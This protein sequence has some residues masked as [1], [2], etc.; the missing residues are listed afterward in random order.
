MSATPSTD[1]T[2]S[3]DLPADAVLFDCD[4]VLVDS[5]ASVVAAWSRWAADVGLDPDEVVPQVHGRR[6][7]DTVAALVAEPERVAALER[8][9]RYELDAAA[10]VT[11]VPGAAALTAALPAG[12]WAV[13][14]SGTRALATARLAAAGVAAPA[15]LV[16]ADDV[17]AGKPAPDGY[18]LAAGR[19]GV[20][21]ARCLVL[22]DAVAGV[23]A[24][25]AAGV[26]AVVGVGERALETDAD[27]VVRDLR[28]VSCPGGADLRVLAGRLR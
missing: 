18:L 24:A 28:E 2:S 25:R 11:A 15:V 19:L 8:I 13:V 10:G 21:A 17:E 16:T 14:T 9:H 23:A 12:R 22:E 5:D 1:A 20:D 26:A 27:V 4:G 6:A 7:A 3:R